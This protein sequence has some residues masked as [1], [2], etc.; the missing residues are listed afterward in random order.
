MREKSKWIIAIAL[1]E[2]LFLG[3]SVFQESISTDTAVMKQEIEKELRSRSE[4]VLTHH[5]IQDETDSKSTLYLDDNVNGGLYWKGSMPTYQSLKLKEMSKNAILL[6]NEI[7]NREKNS[8]Q[9]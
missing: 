1:V 2:V 3:Y 6:S 4:E 7:K 8:V 9:N 5:T